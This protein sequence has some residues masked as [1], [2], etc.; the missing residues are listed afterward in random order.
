NLMVAV[1]NGGTVIRSTDAGSSWCPLN[2]G[3]SA[4]LYAV[5]AVNDTEYLIGG[6]GGLLLRTTTGGGT[7]G[8]VPAPLVP[9]AA[10]AVLSGPFPN[11][12]RAGGHFTLAVDREQNVW[13]DVFDVT[14][15]RM[16]RL[17]DGV[18][19]PGEARRVSAAGDRWPAGVYYVRAVGEDFTASRRFVVVR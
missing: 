9:E 10:S 8:A 17:L 18:M 11:P 4:N 3:T 7:C 13:V 6:A 16:A 15:R 1:G 2:A 5:E 14:G 12:L 19:T